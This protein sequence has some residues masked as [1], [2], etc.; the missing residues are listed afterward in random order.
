M[1][2]ILEGAGYTWPG[3]QRIGPVDLV[4]GPGERVL[5][6]GRSGCGKSTL[7][8]LA[9]GLL[10]RHGTGRITGRVQVDGADPSALGPADRAARVAFVSQ[11]PAD[12]LVTGTVA[13]EVAFGPES[14]GWDPERT[15]RRIGELLERVGLAVG[16]D[17]D[18][19]RLSGGQQQRLV[20][21]AALAVGSGL[22]L[23]DEP[24]AQ[25]DPVGAARLLDSLERLA[26]EG[27]GVLL[28]EHRL[29]TCLSWAERVVV[30]EDGRIRYDG[31]PAGAP[32]PERR[33]GRAAAGD[34]TGGLV[35]A[36]RD[37][38]W[39]WD[40]G[41]QALDGVSVEV[42]TGERVALIGENG[43]GK[44]TLLQALSGRLGDAE[45]PARVVDVPQDPDLSLFCG[46]VAEELAWGPS[47]AGRR[48][49]DVEATVRELA[50]AFSLAG[51][52]DRPPQALSRGQRLRVAV[53]A[54]LAC[55]PDLLLLDEPTSGQDHEA[56]VAMLD[57]LE[58]TLGRSAL[59]FATHDHSLARARATR[60]LRLHQ[61][62]IHSDGPPEGP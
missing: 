10:G 30:M 23:L 52:L 27:I 57:A 8:R 56:V 33:W 36:V 31:A 42:R 20:V 44:S 40:D 43:A 14:A 7:L 60:I 18:P 11:E 4:V 1:R 34:P 50:E 61:G 29:G 21:A 19:R 12:Q 22:L 54:A 2:L 47:E 55:Q 35:A 15:E 62:R 6:T 9:A 58:R 45:V 51:L 39:R 59:V 38:S 17:R 32:L 26:G 24:L 25:L 5:L 46:T 41:T 13:D 49:E 37:F 3:G 48:R 28:V 53:A 16:P